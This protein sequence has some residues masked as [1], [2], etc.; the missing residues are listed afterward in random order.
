MILARSTLILHILGLMKLPLCLT[1]NPHEAIFLQTT[2]PTVVVN[3]VRQNPRDGQQFCS[4]YVSNLAFLA[5]S[6]A[7]VSFNQLGQQS[8]LS[9]N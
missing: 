3:I 1:L 7:Q 6:I 4:S 2:I 8:D 9:P 5:F